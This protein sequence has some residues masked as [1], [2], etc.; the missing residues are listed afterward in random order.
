MSL[1]FAKDLPLELG[2][3]ACPMLE[4]GESSD[5]MGSYSS[6][7]LSFFSGHHFSAG[8][9][10]ESLSFVDYGAVSVPGPSVLSFEHEDRDWVDAIEQSCKLEISGCTMAREQDSFGFAFPS[11]RGKRQCDQDSREMPSPKKQCSR[12]VKEKSISLQSKDSQS[13]A[14]K[15]RRERISERL[16]ILQDLVPNGTKVDLV[17]ML[18]KAIS[19]VKFLQLQVKVLATDEFWPVQGGRTPD[20][21]QV[22]KAIDD[23]LSSQRDRN[24]SSNKH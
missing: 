3:Q 10:R 17:T 14:A 4:D 19:Y 13:V 1:N 9:N 18:E 23:I 15:N 7:F 6:S 5:S 2:S 11:S 16:K 22:K 8:G 12:K 20:I 24:S 21:G